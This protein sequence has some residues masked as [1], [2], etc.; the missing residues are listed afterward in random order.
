M[1]NEYV[2]LLSKEEKVEFYFNKIDSILESQTI[3]YEKYPGVHSLRDIEPVL[4]D[5]ESYDE[6]TSIELIDQML[7]YAVSEMV[8]ALIFETQEKKLSLFVISN[9]KIIAE[10]QYHRLLRTKIVSRL[11]HLTSVDPA[12]KKQPQ[13]GVIKI[14][15][16]DNLYFT[17]ILF[18]PQKLGESIVILPEKIKE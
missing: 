11:K 18:F 8:Q 13:V 10:K 7:T 12:E 9:N 4:V 6:V 14:S 2:H 5:C 16:R 15:Y 17:K 1:S 3:N